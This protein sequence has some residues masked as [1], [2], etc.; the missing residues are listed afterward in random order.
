MGSVVSAVAACVPHSAASAPPLTRRSSTSSAF[1]TPS[2]VSHGTVV[3]PPAPSVSAPEETFNLKLVLPSPAL[4]SIVTATEKPAVPLQRQV[5]AA[6]LRTCGTGSRPTST[7]FNAPSEQLALQTSSTP[8]KL[9]ST[10]LR[11]T[12]PL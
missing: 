5:T 7:S 10:V 3:V 8:R 4:D 2:P 9:W 12:S 11:T 6:P 1:T